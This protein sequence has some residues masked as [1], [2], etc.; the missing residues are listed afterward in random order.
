MALTEGDISRIR[1]FCRTDDFYHRLRVPEELVATYENPEHH[2]AAVAVYVAGLFDEQG[3]RPILRKQDNGF[4]L[5][6]ADTGCVL[7]REVRPLVCRLYPYDWN[8]QHKLWIQAPYCPRELY[9]DETD[10]V[11]QIGDSQEVALKL[12][13]QLYEELARKG[14]QP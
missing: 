10:L 14:E 4:C 12:V 11:L 13:E 6:V 8:D 2:D 1:R 3:R 5:F 9:A 7:P